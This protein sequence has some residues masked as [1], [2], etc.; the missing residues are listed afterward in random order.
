MKGHSQ[1]IEQLNK[2]LSLELSAVNQYLLHSSLI[3]NWGY[4]KLAKIERK[5]SI[6]E[7]EHVDKLIKR[8][9]F[10]EG[11]PNIQTSEP[12]R[13]GKN[14]KDILECDLA[15]EYEAREFYL[16]SRE[17]CAKL[18]DHV[19]KKLFDEL[20]EDE[21]NHID[22]LETQLQ[23]FKTMGEEKYSQLNASSA[24]CEC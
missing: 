22:F 14:L 9:T 11:H 18:S 1:V 16:K 4:I 15:S 21:E 8:I 23:L 6:E 2:A 7:M 3:E 19:S 20:L 10:L 12:L 13:I 17:I 24:E 5:E